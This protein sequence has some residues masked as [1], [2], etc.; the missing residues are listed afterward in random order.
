[1]DATARLQ[2]R[3]VTDE[4]QESQADVGV[5]VP[6]EAMKMASRPVVLTSTKSLCGRVVRSR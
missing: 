5:Q 1:M 6:V 4:V 2:W 3:S